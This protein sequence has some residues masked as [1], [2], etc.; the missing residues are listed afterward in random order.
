MSVKSRI[1]ILLQDGLAPERLEVINESHQHAGHQESFDGTGETH[2]RVRI[3]SEKFSKMSRLERHR[4]VNELLKPE[5]EA[6]LHAL[7]VEASAPGE[8]TRW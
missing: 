7:A 5:L 3:V 6:G 1:E 4:A 8:P 2:M